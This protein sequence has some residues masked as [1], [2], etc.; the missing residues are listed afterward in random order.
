MRFSIL[1][2]SQHLKRGLHSFYFIYGEEPFLCMEALEQIRGEARSQG[3]TERE[4]YEITPH[5]DWEAFK[6]NLSAL[7]LF[8]DKRL[9]E[10]HFRE[11]K[12]SKT[13]G[14]ALL[15]IACHSQPDILFLCSA[16]KLD[17][18]LKK[19]SW[20]TALERQLITVEAKTL[21]PEAFVLWLKSRLKQAQLRLD[22]EGFAILV[23]R[24]E[25]NLLAAA[26]AIEKL[27]LYFSNSP[28][29][30]DAKASLKPDA[31]SLRI[32][33]IHQL[34]NVD[35]RFSIFE[36]IDALLMGSLPRTKQIFFS[37]K[38]E[39]VEPLLIVW[40]V[41]REVRTIIP[42]AG[43]LEKGRSLSQGFIE[44][45]VWQHKQE[46]I[47]RFLNRVT[48][49]FLHRCLVQAKYIDNLLK[50]Q[51]LGDPWT[52]LYALCLMLARGQYV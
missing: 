21:A 14:Q 17:A 1:D 26:Q 24:T 48:L 50:G 11:D 19:A 46:G 18:S 33:D 45:K 7:T 3:Y 42:L 2:L 37:L 9:V 5:F 34:V 20:F 31:A 32:E 38:N 29:S 16:G 10:C 41:T 35:T 30:Q 25:G 51:R 23:E 22:E 13:A 47:R 39:G 44:Q 4:C 28:S 49:S 40:A 36:L 43:L 6:A 8:S 15:E 27:A 52:E 12:I